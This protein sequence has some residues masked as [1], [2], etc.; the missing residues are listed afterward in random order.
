MLHGAGPGQGPWGSG[1]V[2]SECS[3]LAVVPRSLCWFLA[4]LGT[5]EALLGN[6]LVGGA[7]V[8]LPPVFSL[9]GDRD[10]IS[11]CL[12]LLLDQPVLK[13]ELLPGDPEP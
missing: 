9:G 5:W 8:F 12:L 6:W 4:A 11:F 3:P 10:C 7:R 13:F 1:P 2:D